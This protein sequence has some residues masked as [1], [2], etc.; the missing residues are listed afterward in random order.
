MQKLINCQLNTQELEKVITC[1][2]A[3]ITKLDLYYGAQKHTYR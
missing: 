2:S 1:I 3:E